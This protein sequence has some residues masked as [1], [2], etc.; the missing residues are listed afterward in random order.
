MNER[1]D[2]LRILYLEDNAFDADL[3]CRSLAESA[4]DYR[5]T[6]VSRLAAALD[7]LR[8]ER[9]PF[10][11]VL[12]DLG[13]PDGSGMEVLAEVK[14]RRLPLAVVLLTGS[15]SREAAIAALKAG[16]D[17]YLVKAG[18]YLEK[19]PATLAAACRHS[20]ARRT[21]DRALRVFYAATREDDLEAVRRHLLEHAPHIELE[22]VAEGGGGGDL[23]RR[24]AAACD[25]LLLDFNLAE[26]NALELVK[27][28][29]DDRTLDLP[30]VLVGERGSEEE[31]AEALRL[32]VADFLIRQP[33][34]LYGLPDTLAQVA[35]LKQL[36]RE[37]AALR[38]SEQRLRRLEERF[39]VIFEGALD[40]ILLADPAT[41][42]FILGNPAICLM[43]KCRPE[44]IGKMGVEDIHPVED[45]EWIRELFAANVAGDFSHT[46][47]IPVK[48]CDNTV[49]YADISASTV[50]LDGKSY[51]M[52]VFRDVTERH[53]GEERNRL[54]VAALNASRD[55]VVITDLAPRII[56]V[57]PAFTAITGYG[58]DEV[59]GKNPRLLQSGRHGRDFFQAMWAALK[60]DGHWQGEIW[61]RRKDGE[62][63][64]EL[65]SISVVRDELGRPSHYVG[66]KTD[67]TRM[68]RSEEKLQYLAHH[69]PL[70]G[71]PNRLLL[72][73]RL[74]HSLE[75]CRRE[76]RK[77]AV[78]MVNLD[79]FRVVNDS[80]GY[81]VGDE[82]LLAVG[83]RLRESLR[84]EDTLARL[85][86]DEFVVA[87]ELS[88]DYQEAELM[89]RRLQQAMAEPF[90]LA[91]KGE[92][93]MRASIG[94]SLFPQDGEAVAGLLAGADLAV[95][96]AKEAGGNCFAYA[97]AAFNEQA[98][99]S[100]ELETALKRALDNGEFVLHYQPKV[101]LGGGRVVGAEAL[102]RWQ[103]P[104][105]GL[106]PPDEFIPVAERS[107]LIN[108][109]G[110]WVLDEACR[111]MRLWQE[112]GVK[113]CALAVN[114]S[115]R[116]F[117][118][119][120]LAARVAATMK[121]HDL[122]AQLL[123]LELTESMLML[124]P[125]EA[126]VRM[127][128]LK[129][130]GLRLSLD[131]FGTG[132]S[133]FSSL[134]RFPIDQLKI[135]RSFVGEL[136]TSPDAAT[137]AVS[138]IAM[139]HR[140]GL[141]VVAEGVETEAQCGYLRQNGCDEIQGFLFS[142]PLPAA[143]FAELLKSGRGLALPDRVEDGR[144]LLIV[145]DDPNI[146]KALQRL[147]LDESYRLLIAP[148]AASGLEMLAVNPVQVII[149]DQRMP[150]MSGIE[151]LS[152]V[153]EIYPDTVRMVLSGYADLETVV[154]AVNEGALYKFIAKPWKDEQL[155]KLIREAFL[156]YE[157]IIKPRG[158]R[159]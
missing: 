90:R 65:L 51:L 148:D 6:V 83:R 88:R 141:E 120:D 85:A 95:N 30:V 55:G 87:M 81:G 138:I 48:R 143:E 134:R 23:L 12:A 37:Q 66:V 159:P 60:Q 63:Y 121:K 144:T 132:Y 33:G 125:E 133:S 11:L 127:A 4:P 46:R 32:G 131:D 104:E 126:I 157:L 108:E 142:K 45:L 8:D 140:M 61:N 49:F 119:A 123:T 117:Q 21:E 44:E 92:V 97:T 107:G 99:R 155:L 53:R 94:I 122:P 70:T 71:L 7:L 156:Y 77:L 106:V 80:Y 1:P 118:A 82:L 146:L 34:Y 62:I 100:L 84:A 124:D 27:E 24:R 96:Q 76:K 56:S 26:I 154:E 50:H 18:D 102:V 17:D 158:D 78:L 9:P 25:V 129:K 59:L 130:L 43:L 79:R 112:E 116:Q 57:N 151:F 40:G 38:A 54:Q 47:D 15:G 69:D 152:R 114:V 28:L 41:R 153:K 105:T 101:E 147:L 5:L 3:L 74:E 93:F 16:A 29:R 39:R 36:Q 67:L 103:R 139:A 52:G 35:R 135:D 20:R 58:E 73:A 75:H 68:R 91:G 149:S 115:A 150:G 89:A 98:R 31:V 64:P 113:N 86:G 128:E 42:K 111:Q 2:Q 137:I 19:L 72:E 10:D 109:L 14:S 22:G 110:S 145:D 13:L 136:V